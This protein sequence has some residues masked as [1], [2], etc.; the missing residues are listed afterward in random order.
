MTF[1]NDELLLALVSLVRATRPAMLRQDADGFSIDFEA[2]AASKSPRDSDRL[3]LKLGAAM[4]GPP[5][6]EAPSAGTTAGSNN[7]AA[8]AASQAQP[9]SGGRSEG[10]EVEG[11]ATPETETEV[12]AADGVVCLEISA[13]EARQMAGALAK[14][15][16]LQAWP[17]DVLRMSRALRA[18]LGSAGGQQL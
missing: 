17:K 5:P 9:S 13:A 11:T 15:E 7:A 10:A 8:G 18:R 4:Q 2:I 6:A 3:L 16:Q 1:S 12:A 14:L